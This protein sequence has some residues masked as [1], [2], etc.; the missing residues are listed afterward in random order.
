MLHL[1]LPFLCLLTP[2]ENTIIVVRPLC[3]TYHLYLTTTGVL[4]PSIQIS[5]VLYSHCVRHHEKPRTP[6]HPIPSDSYSYT[7]LCIPSLWVYL[8]LFPN[9]WNIF[10]C[11]PHMPY[12]QS[13]CYRSNRNPAVSGGHCLFYSFL[14]WYLY[15]LPN[16]VPL[17]LDVR[18]YQ[19]PIAAATNHHK[20]SGLE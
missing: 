10:P 18:F 14:W 16:Y 8:P 5:F 13:S 17:Y 2:W 3:F 9:S 1:R 4:W 12:G 7:S 20:L 11:L 19:F 6:V 15:F